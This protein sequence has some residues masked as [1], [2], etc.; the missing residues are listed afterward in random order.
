MFNTVDIEIIIIVRPI[1]TATGI[2]AIIGDITGATL[3]QVS[4]AV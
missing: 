3:L 4:L 1:I 2:I